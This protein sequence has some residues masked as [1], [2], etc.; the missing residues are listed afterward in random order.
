LLKDIVAV[1]V[2]SYPK[3]LI[4]FEDGVVGMCDLTNLISFTGVFALLKHP[5]YF[6]KVSL[7]KITGTI[8][9]T[10]GA[11]LDPLV[12]YNYLTRTVK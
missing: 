2:I 12:L 7:N 10:N 8:E 4:T 9:W 11:D 3:L 6:N 5:S 1:E